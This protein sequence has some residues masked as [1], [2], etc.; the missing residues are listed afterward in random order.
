MATPTF[1]SP[2]TRSFASKLLEFPPIVLKKFPCT[3]SGR[4]TGCRKGALMRSPGAYRRAMK[5]KSEEAARH[6]CAAETQVFVRKQ[7]CSV[8]LRRRPEAGSLTLWRSCVQP[9]IRGG[10]HQLDQSSTAPRRYL[11]QVRAFSVTIT[12]LANGQ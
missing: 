6:D 4:Q 1:H 3:G 7:A 5:F 11:R 2:K 10:G 12:N 8:V 9:A